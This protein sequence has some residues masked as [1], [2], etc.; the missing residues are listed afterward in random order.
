MKDAIDNQSSEN[1]WTEAGSGMTSEVAEFV[2]GTSL[3]DVPAV[4]VENGKKSILDGFGLALSGSVAKSG[5]LVRKHLSAQSL[6]DG[7]ST[8]LGWNRNLAPRFAAFANGVGIHADDYDDTQL[9]VA[10]DRVYGLLTHPTAPALPAALAVGEARGAN[11]ADVM[12]AYHLG[13]EV[14][15]K[16]AEA[17]DPRH[18][19]TG[20]HATATC[21]TFA[22]ASAAGRLMGLDQ[23]TLCRALSIAG[24]QSAGLRENFGTMTKP[25]H[26]G[27]ASESGVVAAEFAE[28][29]WTASE[30]ILEAMRGFF[31]AAGGGYDPAAIRGKLGA[32]WTFD[33]PG[34]SIKPHPSG[35]LTH[36][37]MTEML[38]LIR[39]NDIKAEDVAH[40]RV[41]TNSNM[42]NALIHHQPTTELQAKFSMEFCMAILLLEG[43][44]G[45]PEFTDEVVNREDVQA[46]IKKVDFVVDDRAEDA[47]YHKMTT[48]IDI[49]MKDGRTVSGMADFGKGSPANPMS[50]DEVA[51]KFRE[52]AEFAGWDRSRAD[53]VVEMVADFETQSDLGDLMALVRTA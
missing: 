29:G 39:A 35:S 26:A 18:Y 17:I 10:K 13:V 48:Y 5:E 27:R 50:Y 46:M 37:G 21:G 16:I 36:P 11:G 31:R 52:N 42:P 41:G 51:D 22:A 12:L 43:R 6:G 15:C 20:F 49:E 44:G 7:P 23:T 38:D 24:S 34:V 9:A 3:N 40:V 45:L 19:R 47:G 14:E 8:V 2:R 1:A 25:F 32:P 4:V 28:L 53:R 30:N 33:N